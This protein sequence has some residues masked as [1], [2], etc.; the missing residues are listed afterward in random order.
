MSVFDST[1][2]WKNRY[3]KGGKSGL[4][5]YNNLALFKA[6]VINHFILHHNDIN[7]IID[8]GVGDGNQLYF[9]NLNEK[10]Y[11]G[12]DVSSYIIEKCKEQYKSDNNKEFYDIANI[13]INNYTCDLSLSCDVL[14]HLIEDKIFYEYLN[15]LFT[16]SNKYVIIYANNIDKNHTEHVKFRN[17]TK[18]IK[19]NFSDWILIRNIPNKF[20]HLS[21][22]DFYIYEKN[23][24]IN[25]WKQYINTNLLPIIGDHPEGNIYTSHKKNTQEDLMIPKQKNIVSVITKL[26]PK[27][28]LEI[29]F[30]AGFSSLL[31]K[32][33][34]SEAIIN[35]IDINYH[36]YVMP[37][38]NK[39]SS[40]YNN[41]SIILESSHTSLIKLIEQNEKYDL[42]HIDGDHTLKGASQ[43][44]SQCLKLSKPGTV[45]IF[46]DTN[47]AEL[48]NLCNKY[49]Q[50]KL[51]K[52]YTFNKIEG[53]KYNHRFFE[54]N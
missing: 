31:M 29:G 5:S 15:N 16:I 2:Y 12:L 1:K 32:M 43:D 36:N 18:Y 26:K 27:K 28:I 52:E 4:G 35:C 54:V 40:D 22:S 13:N 8:Y 33:S 19:N 42:I 47:I 7:S 24:I 48:N 9:L 17:F 49:V 14:Y 20:K 53:T 21:P 37:C 3:E 38:F 30:N 46:D 23:V 11:I 51:L 6:D 34:Y 39:I 45:I 10:K 50:N 41:I 44:L 25:K